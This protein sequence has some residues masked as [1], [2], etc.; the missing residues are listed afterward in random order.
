ME[1]AAEVEL[2]SEY[3]GMDGRWPNVGCEA[4]PVTLQGKE[5]EQFPVM[6]LRG[7]QPE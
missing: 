6:T 2:M 4:R 1:P 5:P 3:C 7:R